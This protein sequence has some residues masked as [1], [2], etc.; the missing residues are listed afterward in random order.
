MVDTIHTLFKELKQSW[1]KKKK[2]EI[3]PLYTGHVGVTI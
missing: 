3:Y 1:E 2:E